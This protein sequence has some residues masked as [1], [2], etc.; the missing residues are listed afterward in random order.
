MSA[1]LLA[2]TAQQQAEGANVSSFIYH[3]SHILEEVFLTG[4]NI[5]CFDL[6]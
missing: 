3:L 2:A 1:L 6:E 5:L 4:E